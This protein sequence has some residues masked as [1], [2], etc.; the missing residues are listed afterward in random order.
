MKRAS[1]PSYDLFKTI[2]PVILVLIL[3]LML[4]SGCATNAAAPARTETIVPSP[5]PPTVESTST[6]TTAAPSPKSTSA[7]TKR[8]KA[9]APT[10]TAASAAKQLPT[11]LPD[12]ANLA[13]EQN[14][15]C[16]TS[17]PSRLSVGQMARVIQRLNMRS[18]PSITA[19]ILQTNP[20]GTEVEIIGGPV[21]TPVGRVA[22]RWW[23][24]RLAN[25]AEGWS[26]ESQIK[27][28]NYFLEP[29]Q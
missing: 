25:G 19:A 22:Y 20:I 24:I 16:N 15:S 11:P 2:V 5:V 17:L 21:C 13:P 18:E 4:L 10:P 14:A 1:A 3:I 9:D 29:V 7:A 8:A 6:P 26:T 12:A 27:Q 28:A 23:Q